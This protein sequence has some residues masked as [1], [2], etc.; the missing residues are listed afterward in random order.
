MSY[1]SNISKKQQLLR[2]VMREKKFILANGCRYSG[3]TCGLLV[4][5]AEYGWL[6][7]FS[8]NI[9]VTIS[10]TVGAEQGV[11]SEFTKIV[12]PEWIKAGFGMIWVERP[13]MSPTKRPTCAI[14]N[15]KFK[16]LD[17]ET[18]NRILDES[19]AEDGGGTKRGLS[20]ASIDLLEA[21][22]MVS[23]FTLESLK[24]ES[25][26]EDRFKPKKVSCIYVPE[27]S[28]FKKRDT[29]NTWTE[30]LRHPQVPHHACRFLADSNPPED[31]SWWIHDLWWDLL[32]TPEEEIDPT[33]FGFIETDD[34]EKALKNLLII[35]SG[36]CRV[37]FAI[38]DNPFAEPDHVAILEAKYR[39]NN[40]LYKRYILGLC[41]RTTEGSLF[42]ETFRPSYHCV[43]DPDTINPRDQ[44]PET[45]VPEPNCTTLY[46]GW[47][48][49]DSVNSAMV[50]AEKAWRIDRYD[51]PAGIISQR[52][53]VMKFLDELVWVRKNHRIE[54]FVWAAMQMMAFWEVVI[55][56]PGKTH[57]IHWSDSSVFDRLVNNVH[58]HVL[59]YNASFQFIE[60][61]AIALSGPILLQGAEKGPLS[62]VP[63]ID[64]WRR[65][66]FDDRIYISAVNC[67]NL[68]ESVK[69]LKKGRADGQPIQKTSPLK[70]VWDAASYLQASEFRDE[71]RR[72]MIDHVVAAR[73]LRNRDAV[74]SITT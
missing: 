30:C 33:E 69:G 50:I 41:V 45:M 59:V 73:R 8:D 10:Q 3:K 32:D 37:D 46:A 72:D 20:Q 63:R 64:L 23:R 51:T 21:H 48:P 67:P 56:R 66:L 71:L 52:V 13:H 24:D 65:G 14:T 28:T 36:L 70:H 22:G 5:F 4:C 47:D 25:E 74:V 1:L 29:F 18:Q 61:G 26:A 42:A 9:I 2:D 19:V 44:E 7:A 40:D 57:W 54:D 34:L 39:H 31:E 68:I 53:E 38:A 49:G 15:C 27:L 62:V 11:W 35:K 60:T 55:G 43:P 58:Q 6:T 12:L 17:D 16:E